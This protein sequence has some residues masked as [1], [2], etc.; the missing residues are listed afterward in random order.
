MSMQHNI[1]VM[2]GTTFP[3]DTFKDDVKYSQLEPF[4]D[5]AFDDV[6]HHEGLCILFDGMNGEYV[7]VGKVLAKSANHEGLVAPLVVRATPAEISEVKDNIQRSIGGIT[8][9]PDF[10]VAPLVIRHC[11]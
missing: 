4:M 1:Y 7:A 2:I 5:S 6:H 9:L 11:R 10:E 3:Y 8:L